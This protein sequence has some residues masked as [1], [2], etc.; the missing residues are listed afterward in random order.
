MMDDA[1]KHSERNT[2]HAA[3]E[4]LRSIPLNAKWLRAS[5]NRVGPTLCAMVV[6]CSLGS[7]AGCS[8]PSDRGDVGRDAISDD[9]A[10]AMRDASEDDAVEVFDERSD[11][12]PDTSDGKV[13]DAAFDA[14]TDADD[15]VAHEAG[16]DA[17]RDVADGAVDAAVDAPDG[18][19]A[20]DPVIVGVGDI[21]QCL[22]LGDEATS[23][24]VD[25]INPARV[26]TLGDH[27]YSNGTDLEFLLCY[28]PSWGRHRSRTRPAPGNHDYN[29]AR[30]APYFRYFGAAAGDPARGYYSF[31]LGAWHLIALNSNCG[32]VGGCDVGSAQERWLRADLASSTSRCTLAYWHHPRWTSGRST[33]GDYLDALYRA[34]YDANADVVL[35][36]HEHHYERFAPMDP[37]GALDAS[38]GLREFVVGTGGSDLRGYVTV[39]ANSEVREDRTWGVLQM[40][41]RPSSYEWR[42]VPVSGA[43]FTDT[44]RGDCH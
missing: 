31:N 37:S 10:D 26:L 18:S 19:A 29:T 21:V 17:P 32:E 25:T 11:A 20:L 42:F 24:L 35:V 4:R 22:D 8:E 13:S 23:T 28:E 6:S 40:T 1:G 16:P 12:M 2:A 41:L 9:I 43:S 36:G 33:D 5:A 27:V 7:V 34:L 30:A 39:R 44:G 15:A 3:A 14:P 38:R